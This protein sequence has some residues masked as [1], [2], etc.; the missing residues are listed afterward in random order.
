MA[1]KHRNK[2]W[3]RLYIIFH[4]H[5]HFDIVRHIS[6]VLCSKL[7]AGAERILK[8]I[9]IP[10]PSRQAYFRCLFRMLTTRLSNTHK[11][12]LS[13]VIFMQY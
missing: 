6:I 10:P 8:T 12:L 4:D 11:Y 1:I 2:L 9:Y 5:R 7:L 3:I 13:I